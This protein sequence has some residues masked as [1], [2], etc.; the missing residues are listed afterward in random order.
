MTETF[1]QSYFTTDDGLRLEYRD[2]PARTH[3]SGRPVL[4]LHGLTR[5]L[6]DFEELAPMI[7]G[8]GRRVVTAS[9]RGRGASDYDRTPEHYNLAVYA[10]DMLA[11]CSDLGIASAVFVGTSMGGL[12][13]MVAAAQAPHRVAATVLNDIG[14]EIDPTGIARIRSYAGRTGPAASWEEAASMSRDTQGV[15]FPSQKDSSFWLNFARK[16]YRQDASGEIVPNYDPNIAQA[17]QQGS[18]ALSDLW[19]L[20]DRLQPVPTLL[21]KGENSD[22]LAEATVSEM[23]RHKADL[24]VA[25]AAGVGHAPLMTEHDVWPALADFLVRNP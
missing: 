10:Q 1:T 21:I 16:S 15:A 24:E 7:A 14:P 20:F 18:S 12:M 3:V 6:R 19:S 9:Q 17:M 13:T 22:I 5:N 25:I 8:L 23:L 11:L 2:Y 4:C